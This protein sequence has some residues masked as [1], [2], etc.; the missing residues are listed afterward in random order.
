M[1]EDNKMNDE[2][3][4]RS[5]IYDKLDWT[6]RQEYMGKFLKMCDLKSN[7]YV[8]DIGTGTGTIANVVSKYCKRVKAIDISEDML[9]VAR[10]KHNSENIDYKIMNAESIDFNSNMFDCVTARMCF[11]HIN[12]QQAAVRNCH[13][14]LKPNGKFVISEGIP[15]PGARKFYT[16]MFKLKE[17]RRTYTID[18]LTELLE[19]GVFKN[20]EFIIHKMPN[21]SIKNWL[22]NS[23]LSKKTCRKI[24]DMHLDSPEYIKKVYNMKIFDGDIFMDWLFAIVSGVK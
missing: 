7:Y 18:D 9:N 1:N 17:K 10:Q 5:K 11:H 19:D 16:T 2:W 23:G 24:Y 12:D 15:P 21:V 13:D 3:E 4:T 8:C 14:I 20:I 22:D 6:S